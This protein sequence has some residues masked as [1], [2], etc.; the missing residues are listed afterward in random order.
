MAK[1]GDDITQCMPELYI[2]MNWK[3]II[4]KLTYAE[5]YCHL[6]VLA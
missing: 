6:S 1:T 3:K 2:D 5:E 4:T